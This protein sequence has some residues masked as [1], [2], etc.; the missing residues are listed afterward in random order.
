[1]S[2]SSYQVTIT[3]ER[4]WSFYKKNTHISVE[5]VNLLFIDLLESIFNHATRGMDFNINSQLLSFM[6]DNKQQFDFIKANI[7][8]RKQNSRPYQTSSCIYL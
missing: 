3:N 6:S 4:V 5:S 1:M 7:L 8:G 2:D